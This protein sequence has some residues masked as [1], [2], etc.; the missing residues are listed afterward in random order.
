MKAMEG[1]Q[2]L[3]RIFIGERDRW[4]SRPL[5]D[6]LVELFKKE[7]FA[8]ATVLHGTQGFGAHSRFVHRDTILRL[9]QD[10]PVI[11]EVVDSEEKIRGVLPTLE[12][13]LGGGLITYEKV[14]VIRYSTHR[15]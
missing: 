5:T 7:G 1:E 6:T 12:S 8:G 3:M 4:H 10:L 9:S 2:L 14:H 15:E 11:I 13:M